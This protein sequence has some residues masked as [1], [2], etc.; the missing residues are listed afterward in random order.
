[1]TAELKMVEEILQSALEK[2]L[3][4][5]DNLDERLLFFYIFKENFAN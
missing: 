1:M 2:L 5:Q 3:Q 4:Q